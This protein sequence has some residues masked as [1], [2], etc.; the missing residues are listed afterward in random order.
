MINTHQR[1]I[2]D[3]EG[4]PVTVTITADRRLRKTFRWTR[5]A[6]GAITLRVPYH[7]SRQSIDH[8]LDEIARH[9]KRQRKR[10]VGRTDADLQ[11]RAVA[12]NRKY[13]KSELAWTSIRWATN[14]QSRL[15]SCTNGGSTDGHIRISE[16]I[17][18][19]P[20]W[21]VDYVIAHELAHRRYS[22][23]SPEFWAYLRSAFPQTERALGFIHGMSFARHETFDEDE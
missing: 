3:P 18:N 17:R 20:Q 15:G 19:W 11:D 1:T 5:D 12:I 8:V 21:V 13:F 6:E 22:N 7:T 9:L 23:H 14:M 4:K 16:R 2:S 10:S